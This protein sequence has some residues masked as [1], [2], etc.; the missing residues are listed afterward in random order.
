MM[1]MLMMEIKN[2]EAASTGGEENDGVG[3][4]NDDEEYVVGVGVGI[5]WNG[6]ECDVTILSPL[7][8]HKQ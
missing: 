3:N 8:E 6:V 4:I 5:E 2:E 1:V 7:I